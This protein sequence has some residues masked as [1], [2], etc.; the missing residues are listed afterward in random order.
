LTIS[1]QVKN[2]MVAIAVKD[3]GAGI[4]PENIGK[5]FEPLFTTKAKGIGLGLA[6]SRKLAEANGGQIEVKSELGK[7][8]TF[9]LFL[10]VAGK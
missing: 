8:S 10:P 2:E 9:T 1:A 3:T 6:V 4:S 7:G 5:I